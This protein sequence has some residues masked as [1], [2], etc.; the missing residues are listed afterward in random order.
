MRNYDKGDKPYIAFLHGNVAIGYS[1]ID[2]RSGPAG[3]YA[4]STRNYM[5]PTRLLY[6]VTQ[7]N[8]NDDEYIRSQWSMLESFLSDKNVKLVTVFGYG[9]PAT[10]VEAVNIM[11]RAWGGGSVRNMEQFEIIDVRPETEVVKQWSKFIE[12]HHYDYAT[13]FF[14][15]SV[16]SNP[17]EAF[18]ASNPVP[19]TFKTLKEMREWFKPLLDAEKKWKKQNKSEKKNSS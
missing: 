12:S 2:K 15:S 4:K 3:M 11:D 10:D 6:P 9:A 5:T 17:N 19:A 14:E 8:Y 16:A 7:K 1:E 18:S 13:N